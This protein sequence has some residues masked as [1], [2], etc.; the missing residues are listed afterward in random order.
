ML[1]I[2]ALSSSSQAVTLRLEG[3]IVDRW[4]GELKRS[5]EE[6][7]AN[8]GGLVLDLIDVSFIDTNG[9]ALL[10]ELTHGKAS[11]ANASPFITELLKGAGLW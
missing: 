2:T 1:R 3:Q 9:L 6:V 4:V 8:G 10:S 7:R 5:C 11:L